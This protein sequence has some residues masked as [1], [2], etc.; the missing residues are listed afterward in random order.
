MWQDNIG[1]WRIH[2]RND[3]SAKYTRA[4]LINFCKNEN[5]IGVGWQNITTKKDSEAPI[6]EQS[7]TDKGE[8]DMAG[9]KAVNTMRKMKVNDLIWTR[10][11]GVY[12]LCRITSEWTKRKPEQEHSDLDISN[13]VNVIWLR[14]G[15]EDKVPGKVISCFRPTSSAQAIRG[16]ENISKYL[17]NEYSKEKFYKVDKSFELWSL[18]SSEEVEE[19]VLLWLQME[20]GCY[21]FTST[22][23]NSTPLYECTL[24]NKSGIRVFPQVKK[25]D[26]LDARDYMAAI[27]ANETNQVYLFTTSEKYKENGCPNIHYVKKQD[28]EN[29]IRKNRTLLP[30]ITQKWIE[31]STFSQLEA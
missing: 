26:T 13:Y 2:L 1:V 25:E 7:V 9:F 20:K 22:V 6:K 30:T 8:Y 18:L 17:W 19:I 27:N 4:D 12:Y 28:I 5:L 21:V 24:V 10:W 16:M 14:I 23:K 29:F 3:I 31:L 15:T 11:D